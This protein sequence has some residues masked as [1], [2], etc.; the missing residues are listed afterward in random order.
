MKKT[1]ETWQIVQRFI[2]Q[3]KRT[4]EQPEN[5][6][7]EIPACPTLTFQHG[8]RIVLCNGIA[9]FLSP[10]LWWLLVRLSES[11]DGTLDFTDSCVDEKRSCPWR[12]GAKTQEG[13]RRCAA[14]RLSTKLWEVGI[15]YKVVY[16]QTKNSFSLVLLD[17]N[18]CI[19]PV[20]AISSS[21]FLSSSG[22][23]NV[24]K[25]VKALL[26]LL[27]VLQFQETHDL[28][29]FR[30]KILPILSELPSVNSLQ[31]P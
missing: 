24:K 28:V 19:L 3:L 30:D 26:F 27:P 2:S 7:E 10:L 12:N 13:S 31:E 1:I 22:A 14:C 23:R 29:E 4:F 8:T 15:P 25:L 18:D 17:G 20:A 21:E 11:P 6:C 5:S 16:S 9:L